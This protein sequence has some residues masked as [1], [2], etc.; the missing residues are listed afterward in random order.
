MP[1]KDYLLQYKALAAPLIDLTPPFDPT[2]FPWPR[3]VE[4]PN[5]KRFVM[6]TGAYVLGNE[7]TVPH[8]PAAGAAWVFQPDQTRRR[9][10]LPLLGYQGT[11]I[12]TEL[13][14]G[15]P[16]ISWD[17]QRP[18]FIWTK[19]PLVPVG[20]YVRGLPADQFLGDPY[21]AWWRQPSERPLPKRRLVPEGITVLG[22]HEII[23]P[24]PFE[25]GNLPWSKIFDVIRPRARVAHGLFSLGP[26]ATIPIQERS[27]AWWRQAS[28]P[29]WHRRPL[30]PV[31][32]YT[33]GSTDSQFLGDPYLSWWRQPSERL[34]ARRPITYL[35]TY[36]R[37]LPTEQF[38]GSPYLAWWRQPSE[39]L[40]KTRRPLV[41]E[42][43]FR[44][45]NVD[46]LP[47]VQRSL[48]WWRQT[49][50]PVRMPRRLLLE[51]NMP[52]NLHF[53]GI[54]IGSLRAVDLPQARLPDMTDER[55]LVPNPRLTQPDTRL[56][57][58]HRR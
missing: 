6:P 1:T 26:E 15:G 5:P 53:L 39:P 11:G 4:L 51:L 9:K 20:Y 32:Y 16:Y 47:F 55:L 40:I 52:V 12:A 10:P 50:E 31:G 33:R 30:V 48:S 27:L 13:T 45:F 22:N 28:E 36:I 3:P 37:G 19:K 14:L 56:L 2:G 58:P 54:V 38:L 43:I 17:N 46:A 44:T 35:G 7:A 18:A 24:P 49:N 34:H 41:R 23:P 57:Y 25:P 21:L 8:D 42:G 29:R